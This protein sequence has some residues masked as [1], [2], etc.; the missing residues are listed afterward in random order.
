[1]TALFSTWR[2]AEEVRDCVLETYEGEAPDIIPAA[3]FIVPGAE[4]VHDKVCPSMLYVRLINS[5]PYQA[6]PQVSLV[7]RKCGHPVA[8]AMA[9]GV[10]RCQQGLGNANRPLQPTVEQLTE[11]ANL[12]FCDQ[13]LMWKALMCCLDSDEIGGNF[14][15]GT[16]QPLGPQGGVYGGEWNFYTGARLACCGIGEGFE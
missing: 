7:K 5:G 13:A 6:F 12:M 15:V 2:V 4:V 3:A 1:M 8:T 9:V 11:D 10:I 16:Y 14:M